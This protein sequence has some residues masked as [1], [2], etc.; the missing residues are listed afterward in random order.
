[1][2]VKAVLKRNKFSKTNEIKIP[3]ILLR[4]LFMLKFTL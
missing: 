1:M 4:Q 2:Y 3:S